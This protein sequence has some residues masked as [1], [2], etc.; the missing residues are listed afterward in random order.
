[1]GRRGDAWNVRVA[2][3][4]E[5][6]RANEAVLDLLATTLHVRRADVELVSGAGR[7]DKIIAVRGLE[8]ERIERVLTAAAES[9][10]RAR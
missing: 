10:G 4:P 8:R 5:K 3:A 2:A 1:V 6:D 7:R 9:E